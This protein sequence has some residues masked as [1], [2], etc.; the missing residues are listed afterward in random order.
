MGA[1]GGMHH[2]TMTQ[3]QYQQHAY[4]SARDVAAHA[5]ASTSRH[6]LPSQQMVKERSNS[7]GGISNRGW[8]TDQRVSPAMTAS[9]SSASPLRQLQ[10][11]DKMTTQG[12]NSPMRLVHAAS[13]GS[14][15]SASR[16]SAALMAMPT[17]AASLMREGPRDFTVIKD[18]GDGSF[19][20][21]CL[22]DW[23]SPLPSGTLL[24]P[25]QHPT[26][27]PEYLGKRLVAIK[28]MKKPFPS[29]EDCLKLKE[30]KVS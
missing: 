29:W 25:M 19:G 26:T 28:K 16:S 24:S 17:T 6:L 2:E 30:L 9:S 18:V 1:G 21:V 12:S 3:Q 4:D 11:G 14:S 20:T 22:A 13:P 27:R 5:I 8:Q 15:T 10:Q 23:R 7:I